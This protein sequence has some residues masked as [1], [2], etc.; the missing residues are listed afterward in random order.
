M[1]VCETIDLFLNEREQ[2][3]LR[4]IAILVWS[5]S[6]RAQEVGVSLKRLNRYLRGDTEITASFNTKTRVTLHRVR[7]SLEKKE[8]VETYH[9][10]NDQMVGEGRATHVVLTGKGNVWLTMLF[11]NETKAEDVTE[12]S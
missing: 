12:E 9:M 6:E 2:A 4:A 1:G 11:E 10:D 5:R 7:A 3:F 8:L